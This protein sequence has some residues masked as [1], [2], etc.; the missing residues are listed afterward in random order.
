MDLLDA[1]PYVADA[2]PDFIYSADVLLMLKD[3][4][5]VLA[6]SPLLTIH[7]TVLNSV[8]A[9]STSGEGGQAKPYKIPF[10]DFTG[11]EGLA[12]LKMLYAKQFELTSIDSAY[13]AARLATSTMHNSC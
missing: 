8:L 1:T 12:L 2:P 11:D 10:Q 5:A 9:H 4:K 13:T 7:S 6:H 3:G